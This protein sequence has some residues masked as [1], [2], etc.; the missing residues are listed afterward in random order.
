MNFEDHNYYSIEPFHGTRTITINDINRESSFLT[1]KQ[2]SR[3][4]MSVQFS[5]DDLD[6]E[7]TPG[8]VMPSKLETMI[9]LFTESSP[10]HA[11]GKAYKSCQHE[12]L[13]ECDCPEMKI[14][15]P[16]A[17]A[18]HAVTLHQEI[19][20]LIHRVP[21]GYPDDPSASPHNFNIEKN[22]TLNKWLEQGIALYHAYRFNQTIF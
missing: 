22:R 5:P 17:M 18:H 1:D 13:D 15:I 12:T 7:T 19:R 9:T 10:I 20:N 2:E 21:Y 8:M 4:L 6:A 16:T 14:R 11:M 3:Y